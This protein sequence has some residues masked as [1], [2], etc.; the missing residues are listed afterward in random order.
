M[1]LL[2]Y[3]YLRNAP[4]TTAANVLLSTSLSLL[5]GERCLTKYHY[6]AQRDRH[7]SAWS[8]SILDFRLFQHGVF[9]DRSSY[10]SI[11][12]HFRRCISVSVSHAWQGS[13]GLALLFCFA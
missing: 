6:K 11:R 12:V 13:L 7:F 4:I 1:Q 10:L 9:T 2:A 3:C 5:P 8:I